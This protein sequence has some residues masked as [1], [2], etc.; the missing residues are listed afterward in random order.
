VRNCPDVTMLNP[1]FGLCLFVLLSFSFFFFLSLCPFVLL[2][3]CLF[4]LFCLFIFLPF[5]LFVFLPF[6]YVF[7]SFCL[8]VSL[9]FY[10]FVFLFYG[11]SVSLSF[12][13]FVFLSFSLSVFLSFCVESCWSNVWKVSS[14]KSHY[15]CKNS[16]VAVT[17]SVTQWP[18]SGIELP[19]QLKIN[20]RLFTQSICVDHWI[21]QWVTVRIWNADIWWHF[22]QNWSAFVELSNRRSSNQ[23]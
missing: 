20:L 2:S 1:L 13:L 18:R 6:F 10:I 8:L 9:S 19:G 23:I 22:F 4:F 16:K 7:L 11:L 17:D 15:L 14:F 3:C 12:C 21:Y 5:C